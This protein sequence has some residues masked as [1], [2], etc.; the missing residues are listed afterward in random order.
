MEEYNL[1]TYFIKIPLSLDHFLRMN[2][3]N[4]I[5]FPKQPLKR[6]SHLQQRP[7][8]PSANH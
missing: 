4:F 6:F 8:H 1:E 5:E 2:V 7:H 3:L